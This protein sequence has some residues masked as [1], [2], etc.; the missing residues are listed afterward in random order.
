M[1]EAA[2]KVAQLKDLGYA[3]EPALKY[4]YASEVI[5]PKKLLAKLYQSEMYLDGSYLDRRDAY[6]DLLRLAGFLAAKEQQ[7]QVFK[8]SNNVDFDTFSPQTLESF[9]MWR[10]ELKKFYLME[11]PYF[12]LDALTFLATKTE[13]AG[14]AITQEFMDKLKPLF[15]VTL[16]PQ[17]LSAINSISNDEAFEGEY[18]VLSKAFKNEYIYSVYRNGVPEVAEFEKLLDKKNLGN[19]FNLYNNLK[20]R[21]E[22]KGIQSENEI[23][24]NAT[25]N[26]EAKV[27][28]YRTGLR[29][30]EADY[31]VDVLREEFE[32]GFSWTNPKLNPAKPEDAKLVEDMRAFFRAFA[33][34][35]IIG[36]QL[37]KRYDSYL[38]MIPEEIFT[39]RVNDLLK[40][41]SRYISMQQF[42]LRFRSQHPEFFGLRSTANPE[43]KYFKDFDL[44]RDSLVATEKPLELTTTTQTANLTQPTA[45]PITRDK[46]FDK[47]DTE[48]KFGSVV[49]Y[50][51]AKATAPM[52]FIY[53]GNNSKGSPRLVKSDGSKFPGNPNPR[54]FKVI[55]SYPIVEYNNVGYIVTDNG[56]IYSTATG[57]L[58][59]QGEDN[60]SKVQRERILAEANTLLTPAQES[61]QPTIEEN[62]EERRNEIVRS[63]FQD[64][65]NLNNELRKSC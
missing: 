5:K 24:D 45:Q 55:G 23:F 35:G 20:L 34:A 40:D 1:L 4:I 62:I 53:W 37:N 51:P 32:Q 16:N 61:I 49:E 59:Y 48:L 10:N 15:P 39:Y 17:V 19:I 57:D 54:T 21:L 6:G 60:S 56:N 41:P 28:W 22:N 2:E 43:L 9:F 44:N 27:A 52:K 42:E 31:T 38:P 14:F 36:T 65:V 64:I 8:V 13:V 30:P 58:V 46:L 18:D 63:T 26:T 33:Y 47:T 29:I 7:D 12:N 25:F 11:K 50:T 3:N